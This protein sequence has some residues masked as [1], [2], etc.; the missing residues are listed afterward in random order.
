MHASRLGFALSALVVGCLGLA[1]P[2]AAIAYRDASAGAVCHAANGALASKFNF[3]LTTVTNAGTTDAYVICHL[4]MDDTSTTPDHV[5]SLSVEATLPNTGQTVTCVAQASYFH[6]GVNHIYVSQSQT[7]T[8]GEPNENPTL[9][10][11]APIY[12][13]NVFNVLSLNCKMPPGG[14]LGLIQR[15]EQPNS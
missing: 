14:K 2:V 3:T 12:R 13:L 11:S 1:A 5:S 7:Y 9:T 10:W 15:W 6:H 4:P 8:S